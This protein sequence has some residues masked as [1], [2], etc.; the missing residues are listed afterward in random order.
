MIPRI[1][2]LSTVLFVCVAC[3]PAN[4]APLGV[5]VEPFTP[6]ALPP[7][8]AA[9]PSPTWTIAPTGTTTPTETPTATP[10]P[11]AGLTIA[12]L[13]ARTY[14]GGELSIVEIMADYGSYTRYLV[15]YPSDGVAIFGF[16]NVPAGEGP[17]PVVIA[18][19]GYIEPAVYQTLDY[20]THY[21]DALAVAGYLVLHPNL[22]GYLPSEEG[23]NL[24]R[25][26]MAL[27]ILNLIA[28]VKS[29]AGQPGPLE[30]ADPDRIGLWGHSMGGGIST[31]VMTVSPDVDA[32]LLYGAM[33][34]DD[35]QNYER[36][37]TVFSDGERGLEE[38]SAP[39]EAFERISP[40]Y[41]LDRI[42][43]A[44][45]IHH[46]EMDE[47]VPLDWSLDLCQRLSD[48]GKRVECFTYSGQPH[49]FYGEN[50]LLFIDRTVEFFDRWLK[51]SE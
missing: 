10:D 8:A 12:D 42:Q 30:R 16:M 44:V 25:V 37:Y 18:S 43:A 1:F 45:S 23:P 33:S 21:A 35:R 46:G 40:I 3:G 32:V 5:T 36:I 17:F 51:G 20:T 50:D 27:D 28:V 39:P 31:R 19:H 6:T 14:G 13:A 2:L 26:G 22:R 47:E 15:T 9:S 7:L 4:P 49:T 24:F 11:F 41:Y 38:L 34:G 29:Q 48:L